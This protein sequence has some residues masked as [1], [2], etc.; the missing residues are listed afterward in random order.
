MKVTAIEEY[1][2]RCLLLLARNGGESMT[3]S[4]IGAKEG[5]SVPYVSKLLMILRKAGLVRADRGRNGG[6]LL[7]SDPRRVTLGEAMNSLGEPL[8]SSGHCKRYSGE[9][10]SCVH[11]ADCSIRSVWRSFDRIFSSLL[12]SIT[13]ADLVSGGDRLPAFGDFRLSGSA[14][15]PQQRDDVAEVPLRN[16]N[17]LAT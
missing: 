5:L 10:D 3:L 16:A 12:E 7:A 6:Y 2:L 15:S 1:G 9:R 13:L 17:T 4:E 14:S 8:L 11:S